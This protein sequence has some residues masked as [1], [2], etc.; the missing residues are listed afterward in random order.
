MNPKAESR[1]YAEQ[2]LQNLDAKQ[3]LGKD[4]VATHEWLANQLHD[5]CLANVMDSKQR[6][7]RLLSP[8]TIMTPVLMK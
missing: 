6:E 8:L 1:G 4:M 2:F 5:A 7:M 3:L